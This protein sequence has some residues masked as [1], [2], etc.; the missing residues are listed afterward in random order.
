MAA[1]GKEEGRKGLDTDADGE[2]G[3]APDYVD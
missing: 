3:G 1:A 2:I